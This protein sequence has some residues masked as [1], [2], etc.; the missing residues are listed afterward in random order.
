MKRKRGWLHALTMFSVATIT[1][2]SPATAEPTATVNVAPEESIQILVP[3]PEAGTGG[4]CSYFIEP[5]IEVIMNNPA[6]RGSKWGILVESLDGTTL[7]RYNADSLFIPAS[8]IKLFTTAA[9]LQKLNPEASIRSSSIKEWITVT[10]LNSDN[11]YA[12]TLLY[13]IGGFE[14]VKQALT[15]LGVDPNSYRLADGSGLSRYNAATPRAVVNTLRAMYSAP[16]GEVFLAS[17]PIAGVSGTL[18][19]R[20]RQSPAEG[21]VF[22]KTGTLRGVRALSGYLNHPRYGPIVFSIMVNNPRQS[23][24]ALVGAIDEIVLQLSTLSPCE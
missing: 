3:P 8:N 5:A 2:V 9:A 11:D 10:N 15:H 16:E 14:V 13:F 12:N 17:L 22:A 21:V 6:Y 23:G 19:N 20:L 4:V 7:Y 1:W 18:K 24:Q